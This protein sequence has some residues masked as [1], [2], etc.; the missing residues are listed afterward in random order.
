[1]VNFKEPTLEE[2]RIYA[3]LVGQGAVGLV[4]YQG[5]E[6]KEGLVRLGWKH[7][8][9]GRVEGF[10]EG[11]L[12]YRVN[13]F[14]FANEQLPY[15]DNKGVEQKVQGVIIPKPHKAT[16]QST[17]KYFH[18]DTYLP[19]NDGEMQGTTKKERMSLLRILR[20]KGL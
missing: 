18:T 11:V 19:F 2:G 5:I 10:N 4:F 6:Q 8:L 14:Q 7:R 17:G 16:P 9:I 1:M 20:K 12:V 3:L 15:T 13:S